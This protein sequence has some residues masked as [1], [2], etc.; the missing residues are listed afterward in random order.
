MIKHHQHHHGPAED[1]DRFDASVGGAGNRAGVMSGTTWSDD[2][3]DS[4]DM[5][6]LLSAIAIMTS[7]GCTTECRAAVIG[8]SHNK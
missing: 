3:A 5:I 7:A 1:V 8:S 2:A 6:G 4:I